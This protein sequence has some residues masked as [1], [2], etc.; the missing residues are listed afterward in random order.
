MRTFAIIISAAGLVLH[1]AGQPALTNAAPS[2]RPELYQRIYQTDTNSFFP[3]LRTLMRAK[4]EQPDFEVL[5]SYFKQKG[6][7]VSPPF[8][9]FYKPR[10]GL[11]LIRATE[12]DQKKI[13]ALLAEL[14][15]RK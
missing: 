3:S 15:S 9:L 13:K 14:Q 1:A 2:A 5:R 7:D 11:L 12:Q 6:V 8:S 4:G 10:T